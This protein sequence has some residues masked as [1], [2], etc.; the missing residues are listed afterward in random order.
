V[1]RSGQG[2]SVINVDGPEPGVSSRVD[3]HAS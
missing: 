1:T 3:D 2:E